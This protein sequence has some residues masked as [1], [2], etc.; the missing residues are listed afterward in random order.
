MERIKVSNNFFLDEF[1]DP[2]TYFTEKDNG[3]SKIDIKAINC[4]QLLRELNGEPIYINRWWSYLPKDMKGFDCNKFL[5][6]M[7]SK[8]IS[9]W[10]GYRSALC[11]IGAPQSAHK[12]SKAIDPKGDEK[13]L[14]KLVVD[15]IAKFY[16]LGLRR[17]EDIS[18]TKGWL[19]MDTHEK[20]CHPNKVNVVNLKEVV[21][22][23]PIN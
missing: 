3:R 14:M 9:V 13:K 19:H 23:I 22:R 2:V 21:R 8:K 12:L 1:V 4:V 5:K 10:S 11:G 16:A 15:N 20:N 17:L 6:E 7:I 18:I